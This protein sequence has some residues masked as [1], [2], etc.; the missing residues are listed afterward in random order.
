MSVD[1][2]GCTSRNPSPLTFAVGWLALSG[3]LACNPVY[4]PPVRVSQHGAPHQV[5]RGTAELGGAIYG[6][7]APLGAAGTGSMAVHDNLRVELGFDS[8]AVDFATGHLGARFI[9]DPVPFSNVAL[10]LIFDLEAGGGAG[11][12]GETCDHRTDADGI[13]ECVPDDRRWTERASGGGYAGLGVGLRYRAVDLFY[14]LRFQLTGATAVPATF[15]HSNFVGLQ[16][17]ILT[18]AKIYLG[19]GTI[20]YVNRRDDFIVPYWEG[21]LAFFAW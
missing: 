7:E 12:G 4:A 6:V 9:P 21:G 11:A 16:V 3:A 10:A 20:G 19:A 15:W 8:T 2:L 17:R 13:E 14:R 1:M 5:R 18:R